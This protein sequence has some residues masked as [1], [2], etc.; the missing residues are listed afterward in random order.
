MSS[1]PCGGS[2]SGTLKIIFLFGAL[3]YLALLLKVVVTIFNRRTWPAKWVS[4][5]MLGGPLLYVGSFGPACWIFSRAPRSIPFPN[6]LY[7]PILEV[8]WQQ[9]GNFLGKTISRYANLGVDKGC[10]TTARI[11]DLRLV[12]LRDG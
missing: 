5:V 11:P 9:E 7:A 12:R 4:A 10:V 1:L 2:G 8:W 3:V 6:T